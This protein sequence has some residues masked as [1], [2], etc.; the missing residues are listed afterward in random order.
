MPVEALQLYSSV[1]KDGGFPSLASPNLLL[2]C[3]V[4]CNRFDK[5]LELFE[6]IVDS[7]FQ[8]DKFTYGK[9]VQAAVKIGDLKRARE[10]VDLMK[11]RGVRPNVFIYNVL[12][13]TE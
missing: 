6:D 10:V 3:L 13:E 12:N 4:T 1:R 9:A 11:K 2:D 8:P 5:T 7:G